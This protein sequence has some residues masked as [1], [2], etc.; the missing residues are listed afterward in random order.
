MFLK[1]CRLNFSMDL[2][3]WYICREQSVCYFFKLTQTKS[4]AK[5]DSEYSRVVCHRIRRSNFVNNSALSKTSN[6][7]VILLVFSLWLWFYYEHY[8]CSEFLDLRCFTYVIILFYLLS[9]N[10]W[11]IYRNILILNSMIIIIYGIIVP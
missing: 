5:A 8:T 6:C 4:R 11:T 9:C 2:Y 7:R 10:Y 3:V 1:V